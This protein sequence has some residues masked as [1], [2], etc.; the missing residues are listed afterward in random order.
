M[1][2]FFSLENQTAIVTGGAAGIGEAIARRLAKAG[3]T[4]IIAD[5]DVAAGAETAK[6][7]P[8]AYAL[9]V[10]ITNPE[11]TDAATAEIM[12]RSGR[13][14]ILVNNAGIA[15]KAAPIAEQTL[16]DW[17][18]CIAVNMDGVF[19]FCTDSRSH[20]RTLAPGLRQD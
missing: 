8:N 4:V 19:N 2:Q 20:C 14:D 13:I 5:I 18:R 17:H 7:I 12:K 16:D 6:S 1:Q 15:G 10:D 11:S 3:A 9:A